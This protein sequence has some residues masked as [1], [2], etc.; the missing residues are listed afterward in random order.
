MNRIKV[1]EE[2]LFI[3]DHFISFNY[4]ILEFREINDVILVLLNIPPGC[5]VMDNLYC[6]TA[7]GE[8]L[9][10]IQEPGKRIVG[11][12]RSPYVGISLT[13]NGPSIVDFYGRRFY[14]NIENGQILSKD[15]VK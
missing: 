7:N 12:M 3:N 2:E 11:K 14:F 4:K 15:I 6:V 9:W 5:K 13:E 8:V 1:K 10:R